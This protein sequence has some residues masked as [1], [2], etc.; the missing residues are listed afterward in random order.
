MA[1]PPRGLSCRGH[2]IADRNLAVTPLL[3]DG[4]AVQ[5][6]RDRSAAISSAR[7]MCWVAEWVGHHAMTVDDDELRG[8]SIEGLRVIDASVMPAVTLTNTTN[9]APF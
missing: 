9:S 5:A 3:A 4:S 6:A 1:G 7:R 2:R 8:R